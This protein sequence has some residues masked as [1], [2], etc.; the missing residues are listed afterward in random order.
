MTLVTDRNDSGLTC[1]AAFSGRLFYSGASSRVIE[2][3]DKS[4]NLG[5]FV[6]F[7]QVIDSKDNYDKCYQDAD[8]TSENISDLLPTDGGF[9]VIS[10]AD[11]IFKLVSVRNALIV[12]ADNG[13][14]AIS[15]GQG[16]FSATDFSVTKITEVACDAPQTIVSADDVIYFWARGG[17]YV[18][19][20]NE[21]TQLPSAQNLTENT[22][23]GFYTNIPAKVDVTPRVPMT[24]LAV[25]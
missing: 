2:G 13:V 14:W 15:G 6:F 20:T 16:G 1:I 19:A 11:R 23:Q 4:P 7:T 17:I 10:Q 24:R 8:P 22:I 25:S 21:I 5:T 3:D 9:V 12:F 18:L